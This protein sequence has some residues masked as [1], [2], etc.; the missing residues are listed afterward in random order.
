MAVKCSIKRKRMSSEA[1]QKKSRILG[2]NF[3]TARGRLM[4]LLMFDMATRL[5]EARCFRCGEPIH[6]LE[7]FT[8]EHKDKWS[9][10]ADPL[11]AFF[12][13]HAHSGQGPGHGGSSWGKC[14]C[15]ACTKR[16]RESNALW[17]K[18]WRAAGKDKSRRNYQGP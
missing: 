11:D 7:E 17:M 13:S 1:I 15:E 18:R 6:T 16:R 10:A 9:E 14:Q 8:I 5:D 4:R 12:N 2:M 3:G